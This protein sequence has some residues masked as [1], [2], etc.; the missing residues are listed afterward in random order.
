MRDSVT[1]YFCGLGC[2]DRFLE[3][4]ADARHV[5]PICAMSVEPETAAASE[6]RDSVTYY[7]CGLGCRDRFLGQR[8]PTSG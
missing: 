6:V 5:D 7:F 8:E 2:R 1:Y 4:G 3:K